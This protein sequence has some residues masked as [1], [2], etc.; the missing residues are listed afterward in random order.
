MEI[1]I[2]IGED[3]ALARAFHAA[4]PATLDDPIVGPVLRRL[5]VEDPDVYA[6]IAEVDRSLIWITLEETPETRVGRAFGIARMGE[7]ARRD[8][9]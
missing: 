8:D 3:E 5:E 1:M 2:L 9:G 6:A 7:Q 4:L